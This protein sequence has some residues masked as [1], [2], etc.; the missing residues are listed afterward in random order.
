MEYTTEELQFIKESL[1]YT[2][3]KFQG[4]QDYPSFE[5]KMQR[6]KYVQSIIDKTS[7]IIK[8]TR[9]GISPSS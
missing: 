7:K 5:F 1:R 4:Y 9:H 6:V 2:L 8:D 3:E